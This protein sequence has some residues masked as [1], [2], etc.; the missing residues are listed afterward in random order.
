MTSFSLFFLIISLFLV[1]YVSRL[2]PMLYFS[3][4]EIPKWFSGWMKYVP[5]SLFSSLAFK[6][7]FITHDHL[8]L[9]WN[10]K[11]LAM[12]LVIFIAYKTKSMALSVLSGLFAIFLLTF[13]FT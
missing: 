10:V 11:I 4:K 2:L 8:D 1:S 6:D 7:V 13:L 5:V 9:L 12:L 3:K